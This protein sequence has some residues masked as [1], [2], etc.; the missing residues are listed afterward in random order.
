MP[1]TAAGATGT[2]PDGRINPL[3]TAVRAGDF[4]FV[5]GLMAKDDQGQ[6]VA[7]DITVQ[8]TAVLARLATV[9]A[10]AGCTMDDVVKCTVWL[11]DAVDFPAFNAIYEKTFAPPYPARSAVR[12]DLLLPGARIELEAVCYRPL[13]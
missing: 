13:A 4:V 11:T 6:I 8:T 5:S 2:L 10:S 12:G 1:R 7:G 3:S 9:V